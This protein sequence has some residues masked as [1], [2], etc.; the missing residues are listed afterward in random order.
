M[1][2][3]SRVAQ[4]GVLALAPSH[5]VSL[6]VLS[7]TVFAA[8]PTAASESGA[9][10][11]G[12]PRATRGSLCVRLGTYCGCE[13]A[14]NRRTRPARGAVTMRAARCDVHAR[15]LQPRRHPHRHGHGH[16]G[17]QYR[18]HRSHHQHCQDLLTWFVQSHPEWIASRIQAPS[19]LRQVK[20]STGLDVPPIPSNPECT[21]SSAMKFQAWTSMYYRDW[22]DELPFT[23]DGT[24]ALFSMKWIQK[25][26]RRTLGQ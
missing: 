7:G 14:K 2:R 23:G 18:S 13:I 22:T 25:E 8:A 17:H 3:A 19:F 6:V 26:S 4:E 21:A 1:H 9:D 20:Q 12:P 5:H 16:Q 15:A 11:F 24:A 10:T